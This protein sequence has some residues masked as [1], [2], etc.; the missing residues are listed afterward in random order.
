MINLKSIQ[1]ALA[2]LDVDGW[3]FY[4]FHNRD[5]I[6]YR[7]LGLDFKKPCSRRWFCYVPR[8]GK[9]S[10]LVHA[11][12]PRVLA[13]V[14]GTSIIYRGHVEL[15]AGLQSMLKG[16]R[17]VAMQYS[18]LGNIPTISLTDAGT[19]ELV[20]SLGVD[21][22]SSAE[23][24]ARIYSTIDARGFE[25][26]QEAGRKVQ[27]IKNDAFKTIFNAIKRG[28]KLDEWTLQQQILKRFAAENLTSGTSA[29]I[30]AI[31]NHAA[32]PHFEPTQKNARVFQKNDRILLD[33]WAKVNAPGA[34]YYDITWCGFAGAK[35]PVAYAKQFGIAMQARD[36]A[37]AFATD[38]LAAGKTVR[39]WE[40]D[41]ACRD[42]IA[43][44][45]LEPYFLHRTGHSI[46]T[47]VHGEG[48]NI[49]GL[50]TKDDRAILPNTCFSVEPGIYKGGIGVRTEVSVCVDAKKRVSVYGDVQTELVTM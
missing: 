22:A 36:A 8:V 28:K 25:L 6:G 31:N 21:V 50:E 11:I 44:A 35:P 12:E 32:D 17:R 46:D 7:V 48:A 2:T 29:P 23:L 33:I 9:P 10:K 47:S 38:S 24:V 49:D 43:A 19:V 34:I 3:L 1:N 18:P 16:V 41:K 5:H 15:L 20:R 39:G 42:V 40:I 30:I 45:N 14:P 4:D 26:H 13:S 37:I 27:A